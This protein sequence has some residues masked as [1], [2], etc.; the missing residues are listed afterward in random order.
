MHNL[1]YIPIYPHLPQ[2]QDHL[3]VHVHL[4]PPMP[5]PMPMPNSVGSTGQGHEDTT[6]PQAKAPLS[7]TGDC[8][9]PLKVPQSPSGPKVMGYKY[10]N[11]VFK[12][13][14][15]PDDLD[16]Y[17]KEH[18][19]ECE[20]YHKV[21]DQVEAWP[22]LEPDSKSSPKPDPNHTPSVH[23]NTNTNAETKT[24]T[25]TKDEHQN[26]L[27]SHAPGC[28][29]SEGHA[30]QK[31]EQQKDE[32]FIPDKAILI[33]MHRHRPT[34]PSRQDAT[35]S[36]CGSPIERPQTSPGRLREIIHP[37]QLRRASIVPVQWSGPGSK[38]GPGP[39]TMVGSVLVPNQGA[40]GGGTN[41]PI[42]FIDAEPVNIDR[43]GYPQGYKN[44]ALALG[45]Y[46]QYENYPRYSPFDDPAIAI[47]P[48]PPRREQGRIGY[49]NM[50]RE[51]HGG[52]GKVEGDSGGDVGW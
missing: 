15:D 40:R 36:G 48:G 32:A 13:I 52:S 29:D 8:V 33:N 16:R 4:P 23:S 44:R 19:P 12:L 2:S 28:P 7:S 25:K 41:V 49:P 31:D 20:H 35:G 47:I 1:G 34:T 39:G 11:G 50:R 9:I 18:L 24:K 45:P 27:S 26:S 46:D 3:G 21:A 22:V 43:F 38:S 51:G 5:M 37:S 42:P 10:E 30:Q 17:Q 14:Y 6:P